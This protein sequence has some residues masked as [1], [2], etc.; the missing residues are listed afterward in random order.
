MY[1][2]FYI[3]HKYRELQSQFLFVLNPSAF[4]LLPAIFK[5]HNDPSTQYYAVFI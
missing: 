5:V 1:V 2:H 4:A 3:I